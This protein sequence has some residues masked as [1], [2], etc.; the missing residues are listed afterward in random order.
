MLH[1]VH[2]DD[3]RLAALAGD[4]PQAT[5]DAGLAEHIAGC[6]RCAGLVD[7]LRFLRASL[8]ELPD[9]RPTRSIQL[10]PPVPAAPSSDG[11][12]VGWLRRLAAPTMVAGAGLALVGAVG[13]GGTVLGG[14][15]SSAGAA[16]D[17]LNGRGDG[18]GFEST[19]QAPAT[20]EDPSMSPAAP[21]SPGRSP[22]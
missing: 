22:T 9:L 15:A 20:A 13:L 8:A 18:E 17:A 2:P 12:A 11:G 16:P 14:M 5:G 4:D 3:E 1:P 21:R 7:E 10:L 6:E 19:S